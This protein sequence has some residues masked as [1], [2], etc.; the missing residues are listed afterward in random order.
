MTES[1]KW[2]TQIKWNPQFL[3]LNATKCFQ[4]GRVRKI[5]KCVKVFV[6]FSGY[7]PRDQWTL[8]TSNDVSK[9]AYA[10]F[11]AHT[12]C[13][14]LYWIHFSMG[15]M[16]GEIDRC[17]PRLWVCLFACF[18]CACACAHWSERVKQRESGRKIDLIWKKKQSKGNPLKNDIAVFN[19]A[20]KTRWTVVT[21]TK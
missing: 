2:V 18:V 21:R 17:F 3:L 12:H 8:W 9:A 11:L 6:L 15:Q 20:S 4:A 13:V 5:W 10:M 1:R 16:E 14:C 7:F 19:W